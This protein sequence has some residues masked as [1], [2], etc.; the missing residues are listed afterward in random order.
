MTARL[1]GLSVDQ[2]T[3]HVTYLGCGW[4][5]RSRTDFV[6]DAVETS[7]KVGAPVQ[8]M[9]TREEDMQHDFYR[10]AAH[11]RLEGAVDAD[12]ER[13]AGV[14]RP[15]DACPQVIRAWRHVYVD[16][17]ITLRVAAARAARGADE[18]PTHRRDVVALRHR[19]HQRHRLGLHQERN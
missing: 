3:V 4:G 5:R 14:V 19:R 10:P 8:V 12:V 9:W 16:A 11:L 15:R 13:I 7:M 17:R 6:E 1:T 2:V 18:A